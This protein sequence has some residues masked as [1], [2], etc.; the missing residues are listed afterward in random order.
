MNITFI[1]DLHGHFPELEGGDVLVIAGDLT[2][3]DTASDMNKFYVWLNNLDY[4][5]KI[6]IAGNHDNYF[7]HCYKHGI[8]P[9]SL[10]NTEYLCDSGCEYENLRFFGS[11]WTKSFEGMNPRCKAFTVDTEEKLADKF[12]KIPLDTNILITHS[13]PYGILDE[14]VLDHNYYRTATLDVLLYDRTGSK[15]LLDKSHSLPNL[16]IH[17]FGH[18]HENYGIFYKDFIFRS[19]C[20]FSKGKISHDI[21]KW[22][23]LFINASHVDENYKPVNPPIRIEI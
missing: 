15:S 21:E 11:P 8:K 13:P 1:S 3:R 5:K 18:I 12:S 19:G 6:L 16:K 2:D 20:S 4:K 7:F 17:C 10:P 23:T 9:F 22:G 14:V